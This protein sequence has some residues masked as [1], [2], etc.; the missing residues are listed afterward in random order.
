MPRSGS[1][2]EENVQRKRYPSRGVK[3]GKVS[4]IAEVFK[5][6][7][8][9][10]ANKQL[11]PINASSIKTR[12]NSSSHNKTRN[13][14][15][16]DN[17]KLP[18]PKTKQEKQIQKNINS[19]KA[20]IAK[21]IANLDK[22]N[23]MMEG[24]PHKAPT[25]KEISEENDE[26]NCSYEREENS[27]EI[28][29]SQQQ[30]QNQH[31]LAVNREQPSETDHDN[32]FNEHEGENNVE[33]LREEALKSQEDTDNEYETE[34]TEE[35]DQEVQFSQDPENLSQ[36]LRAV[37]EKLDKI[38]QLVYDPKNSLEVQLAKQTR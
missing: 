36:T 22:D 1:E 30:G 15:S 31:A 28:K 13:F 12:R 21:Q 3:K 10:N 35:S 6:Q 29:G 32:S 4:D 14:K 26:Q 20:R 17:F 2:Q 27:L 7:M 11:S 34:E 16:K 38:D 8:A 9:V 24:N 18:P 19:A 33:L 25:N 5:R 23:T 37:C